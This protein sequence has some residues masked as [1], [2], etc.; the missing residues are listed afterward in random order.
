M[1]NMDNSST[2]WPRVAPAGAASSSVKM[3]LT[4]GSAASKQVH[5]RIEEGH[6]DHECLHH[7]QIPVG[8][9]VYQLESDA[10]EAEKELNDHHP[11]DRPGE[12]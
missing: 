6:N 9:G 7:G 10:R 5:H 1:A 8:D 12:L 2:S 4:F 3:T 11:S